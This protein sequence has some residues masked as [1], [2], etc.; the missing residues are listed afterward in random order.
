MQIYIPEDCKKI[1]ILFSGGAD[2]TAL[3]FLLLK[4]EPDTPIICHTFRQHVYD[5]ICVPIFSW[6]DT[7]VGVKFEHKLMTKDRTPYIR[8]AVEIITK[9]DLGY[10]YSGCNKVLEGLTPTK[11]VPG[12]TPPIRG[13]AAGPLHIR[14]FIDLTKDA[15]LQIYKDNDILDLLS[16]TKSCGYTLP[17]Q[18]EE[19]GECYFCLEKNWALQ[20]IGCINTTTTSS[21]IVED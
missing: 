14:P 15:I 2:S 11:Y 5:K 21:G 16:L 17:S 8:D 12:D 7:R 4:Q 1:H 20:K 18:R 10:V 9:I 3:L 13:L 6:F 19:C